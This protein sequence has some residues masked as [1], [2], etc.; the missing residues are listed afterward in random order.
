MST[1][2]TFS[3]HGILQQIDD[4][5]LLNN[6]PIEHECLY[7][8]IVKVNSVLRNTENKDYH[9]QF[10]EIINGLLEKQII[11]RLKIGQSSYYKLAGI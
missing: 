1:D 11:E 4:Y 5:Q 6:K 7:E 9:D 8:Q 2:T 10:R 3:K